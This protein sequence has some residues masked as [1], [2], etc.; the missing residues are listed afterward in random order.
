[1]KILNK[2]FNGKSLTR[3]L[4]IYLLLVGLIPLTFF[5]IISILSTR[6][7]LREEIASSQAELVEQRQLYIDYIMDDIGSLAANLSG[8]DEINNALTQNPTNSS[9]DRLSMQAK[10]GYILNGYTNLNG[11]VSID[12]FSSTGVHYHVGETLNTS[13]TDY[14][15]VNDLY[16]D[17]AVKSE[18]L[19]WTGIEKNI[20]SDSKY[21]LVIMATKALYLNKNSLQTTGGKPDGLLIISYD[22]EVFSEILNDP[23]NKGFSTVIDSENRIVYHPSSEYIGKTLSESISTMFTSTSGNFEQKVDGKQML[24]IYSKTQK[25][26]WTIATFISVSNILSRSTIITIIFAGLLCMAIL[27]ALIFGVMIS[28]KV[29]SPIRRITNTFISLKNGKF[30]KVEKLEIKTSDEIGHLGQLFNSFIDAREDITLQKQLEKQLSRQN[31][32]LEEAL[33]KLKATQ[34]QLFQQEKLVGIGQLAGGVAHEIN[35]PINGIMNYAQL[36][37]DEMHWDDTISEYVT[38]IVHESERVAVI[39]KNLLRFARQDK[40]ILAYSKIDDIINQTLSLIKTLMRHD[41]IR[42]DINLP[43]NLPEIN[44]RCQQIQQV[45]MNLLSNARDALN[46]KYPEYDENKIIT[47]TCETFKKENKKWIRI[48]VEDNGNGIPDNIKSRIFEPFFTTKPRDKGTGL[49]LSISHGIVKEH[50]GDLYFETEEGQY[51][52][53]ILELPVDNK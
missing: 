3:K 6:C 40:E 17:P 16:N 42:L 28:K 12:I 5:G 27:S 7:T 26:N 38:E 2:L 50:G 45:L 49:G 19:N 13:N 48:V 36:I 25:G 51:T 18:F 21:P 20:N 22:P 8:I 10:I 33:K 52:R 37:L 34:A 41:Q 11:L 9:Y 44:C 46:Q 47:I 39:V 43:E 35:N 32:E 31:T 14:R 53:A 30:D 29:V 23:D 24:V 15:L 4:L 1:M